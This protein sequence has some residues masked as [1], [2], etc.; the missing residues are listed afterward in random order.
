M[1]AAM[2]GMAASGCL[3]GEKVLIDGPEAD[4]TLQDVKRT[5]AVMSP[6]VRD[7]VLREKQ[8]I[9]N[10]MDSTYLA[11]VAAERARRHGLDKD[12]VVRARIW[13]ATLNILAEAEVERVVEEQLSGADLEMA[14][15]ERYLL[16]REKYKEPEEVTA[17]HIL[18]RSR[19]GKE[20]EQVL[21]RIRSIREEILSGKIG[22]EEA[23]RKYSEDGSAKRGGS[24]GTFRRGRMVEPFEEAAF[25]LKEGEI[26]EPVKTPFGYHLIRVEKKKEGHLPAY[27][28]IRDKLMEEARKEA[29]KTILN[30]FWLGIR[31]DNKVK[32]NEEAIQQFLEEPDYSLE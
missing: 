29:R 17:S 28:E 13:H 6:R 7:N 18:L 12:P 8:K 16:D 22:F 24:L 14:A 3:A 15:K 30:D 11:K 31:D 26:S 5:F 27:E 25:A 1:I 2:L 32:L 19:G 10:T 4:L 9:R 20:D 21:S 23:A